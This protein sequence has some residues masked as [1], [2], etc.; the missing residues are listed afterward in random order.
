M[1]DSK[2]AVI[3]TAVI[4][5]L[6]EQVV[7]HAGEIYESE[8]IKKYLVQH[9]RSEISANQKAMEDAL[10]NNREIS[11]KMLSTKPFEWQYEDE[12]V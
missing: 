6:N 10:A 4:V 5:V 3:D 8:I 7:C 9:H 11:Q 1:Y 12:F 2:P